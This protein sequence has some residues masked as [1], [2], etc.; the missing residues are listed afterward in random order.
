MSAGSVTDFLLTE[1]GCMRRCEAA[2]DLSIQTG[3][4]T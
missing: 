3:R 4:I 2:E 1:K